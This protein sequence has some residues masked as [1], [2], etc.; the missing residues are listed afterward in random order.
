MLKYIPDKPHKDQ[1]SPRFYGVAFSKI[2]F[3]KYHFLVLSDATTE[4]VMLT[5]HE[6]T[7]D[8]SL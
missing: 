1:P 2:K 5:E 4:G 7:E 6:L 8:I 3:F